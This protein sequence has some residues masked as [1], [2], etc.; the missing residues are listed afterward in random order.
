VSFCDRVERRKILW[1][2]ANNQWRPFPKERS[3]AEGSNYQLLRALGAITVIRAQRLPG[4]TAAE[5]HRQVY[6][7]EWS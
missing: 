6:L 4:P 2:A 5:Q 7:Q 3:G 1:V